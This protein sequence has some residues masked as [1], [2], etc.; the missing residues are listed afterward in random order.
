MEMSGESRLPAPRAEVWAAL[1]DPDVLRA[2]I[3]GC[4]SLEATEEGGFQ[5]V[6]SVKVGPVKAR[7]AGKVRLSDLNPPESY[8]ISG[9]GQGGV[10]GFAKGGARVT[11]EEVS[12]DETLLRYEVDAN[13][14][15]KLAQL[16]GRLI[17]ATA[18]KLAGQFFERFGRIVAGEDPAAPA[19]AG[20]PAGG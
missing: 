20:E 3:P 1:N 15:G 11:L 8:A 5:A 10:A 6:V 4:E 16:G 14:G 19:P 18:R 13:V 2:A 9:E 17:D 12:A 7:F